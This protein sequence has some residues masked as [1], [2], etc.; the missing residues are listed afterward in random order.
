MNNQLS[1]S[2]LEDFYSEFKV[3]SPI[4][5]LFLMIFSFGFYIINWIYLT[6]LKFEKFDYENSPDPNRGLAIMFLLPFTW[7]LVMGVF[8]KV[9]FREYGQYVAMLEVI[10]WVIVVLLLLQYLY[11]FCICYGRFTITNGFFFYLFLV[12]GLFPIFLIPFGLY[13]F[14]GILVLPF[15]T[16]I[17]MQA[18][19]NSE[20]D[21]YHRKSYER[22]FYK[23]V[24][25]RPSIK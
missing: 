17:V 20:Y 7:L 11:D 22:G 19:L 3:I 2:V 1:R 10:G 12:V 5:I 21:S 8:K 14:L 25:K 23:E 9:I 15:L 13:L 18:K 4:K 16:I 24:K 6:N